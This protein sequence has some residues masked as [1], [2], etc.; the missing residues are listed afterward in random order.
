M[1]IDEN[2]IKEARGDYGIETSPGVFYFYT[3]DGELVSTVRVR[4]D[5]YIIKYRGKTRVKVYEE[6]A[7][8]VIPPVEID[9]EYD[10][11]KGVFGESPFR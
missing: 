4:D 6:R 5:Y 11:V 7:K 8:L 1:L 3:N 9:E 10:E 2:L